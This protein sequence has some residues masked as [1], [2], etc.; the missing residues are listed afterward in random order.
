MWDSY[1]LFSF[2]L[3]SC[4]LLL[5][6]FPC[7][8]SHHIQGCP[9]CGEE[10][11]YRCRKSGA[12]NEKE[13]SGRSDCLCHGWSAYCPTDDEDEDDDHGGDEDMAEKDKGERLVKHFDM[14]PYPRDARCGC[15][16]CPDCR[17]KKPCGACGGNW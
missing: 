6:V 16:V 8:S 15:A 4:L 11:C 13:R 14:L 1:L 9:N 5:L 12:E 2:L 3:F 7:T 10:W 17:F